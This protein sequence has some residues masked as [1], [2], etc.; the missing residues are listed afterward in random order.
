MAQLQ[1]SNSQDAFADLGSSWYADAT[2]RVRSDGAGRY[3]FL[4]G[5]TALVTEEGINSSIFTV[6]KVVVVDLGADDPMLEPTAANAAQLLGLGTQTA[7]AQGLSLRLGDLLNDPLAV[8]TLGADTVDGTAGDDTLYGGPGSD[9]IAGGDGTDTLQLSGRA[10]LYSVVNDGK[11]TLTITRAA[12]TAVHPI[13]GETVTYA[14]ATDKVTGVEYLE[15]TDQDTGEIVTYAVDGFSQ[16]GDGD[17]IGGYGNDSLTGGAGSDTLDGRAG[18]DAMKGLEG[19]DTYFVDDA[20]DTVTEAA[21]T[22][23]YYGGIDTVISRITYTLGANVENLQLLGRNAIDGTGNNLNNTITGNAGANKLSGGGGDDYFYG[24]GGNDTIDGGA[25]TTV[26]DEY[27]GGDTVY[28]YGSEFDYVIASDG[29]GGL[30]FSRQAYTNEYDQDRAAFTTKVTGIERVVFGDGTIAMVAA[31]ILD[32]S[33]GDDLMAAGYGNDVLTGTSGDDELNGKVGADKMSGSFGNDTYYVD[34]AKDTVTE[35]ADNLTTGD[36]GGDDTVNASVSFVLG[37][38]LENLVLTGAGKIDG[39]GNEKANSLI[40]NAGANKLSGMD[41]NDYI[42]A[43]GGNDVIDGGKNTADGDVVR[44]IGSL[45]D[46]TVTSDGKGTL[47][48]VHPDTFTDADGID[49]PAFTVTVKGAETIEFE[50]GSSYSTIGRSIADGSEAGFGNDTITGTADADEID[51]SVGADKMTGLGGDDI[52]HVDDAKDVV[53]EAANQGTDVVYSTAAAYTLAANVE[54]LYLTGHGRN[55]TGNGVANYIEG[56]ELANSLSGMAGDDTLVSNGGADVLDGG[57]GTDLAI[58]AGLEGDYVATKDSSGALIFTIP[59]ELD[60][61]GGIITPAS[62][63]KVTKVE[64]IQF[65]DGT[66]ITTLNQTIDATHGGDLSATGFGNDIV[67]GTADADDIDGRLGADTMSGGGGDDVYHVD[68]A[69]DVVSEVAGQGTD[70]VYSSVSFTLGANVEH[71]TLTGAA[72]I[73]GTGNGDANSLVGN[74]GANTLKGMGGNDVLAGMGGNDTLDGGDGSDQAVFD[75]SADAF[76]IT[77]G[78]GGAYTLAHRVVNDDGKVSVDYRVNLIGI[79]TATFGDGS[80]IH[81]DA[82][83]LGET[84][85]LTAGGYGSDRLTGGAASETLDGGYGADAMAGNGGDDTYYVDNTGDSVTEIADG[86][87]DTVYSSVTFTLGANVENLVLSGS[88]AI[89]GTGNEGSNT[90]IGNSGINVLN[91]GGG[92]DVLSGGGGNDT[93]IGGSGFDT[94]QF[95]GTLDQY[96]VVMGADGVATITRTILVEDADTGEQ[97]SVQAD[98]VR[99]DAL[100]TELATFE[101]GEIH[102]DDRVLD[103]AQNDD[104]ASGGYGK[105]TIIGSIGDDTIDGGYGVDTMTG[106]DGNDTYYVDNQNDKI[107][108]L[109]DEGGDTVYASVSYTLAD[110]LDDLVLQ[111]SAAI[112]GTGNALANSITGNEGVNVLNGGG[113]ADVMAGGGGNDTF[114]GGDGVDTVMFEGALTEY[115]IDPV[116]D[117]NGYVTVKHIVADE[118]GEPTGTYDQV[119]KIKNDVELL[120]FDQIVHFDD[121]VIDFADTPAL[122]GYGHDTITGTENGDEIDGGWNS[123]SMI[124]GAGDDTYYVDNA[125]DAITET[126]E[127]GSGNDTVH[128]T[129][130]Y[131]LGANVENLTLEDGAGAINGTGNGL[132]NTLTGNGAVNTLDGGDGND[133]LSGGGGND[134]LIGGGGTDTATFDGNLDDYTLT[135]AYDATTAAVTSVKVINQASFETVTVTGVE[136][137]HFGDGF[138]VHFGDRILDADQGDDPQSGGYGKETIY[139]GVGDDFI[140]GGYAA[141]TMIGGDGNDTY[142]VDNTADV[143]SEVAGQGDDI[144]YATATYTLGAEVESLVLTG[145]TAINGTGNATDNTLTGNLG[146]NTLSGLGGNDTLMGGGGNDTLIGG[147]GT[148]VAVFNGELSEYTATLASGKV[149]L[150]RAAYSELNDDGVMVLRPAFTA[151][152]DSVETVR[153]ATELGDIDIGVAPV[154]TT[155]DGEILGSFAADTLKGGAGGDI[156]NGYWGID[157][158]TGGDGDDTYYVDNSKDVITEVADQGYDIVFASDT[159]TLGANVEDLTLEGGKAIN[160]TGNELGNV[161]EGNAAANVLS[162]M[163]GDDTLYGHGGNDTIDGGANTTVVD[164]FEGGDHV[165][166]EGNLEDFWI[167]SDGTTVKVTHAAEQVFDDLTGTW[168]TIPSWT[169]SVTKVE[170]FDFDD[171]TVQMAPM[172]ITADSGID[173]IGGFGNDTIT[174]TDGGD[175]INGRAGGDT[176]TGGQGDDHYTVDD[177][178]D[179]VKESPDSDLTGY[180]GGYDSVDAYVTY[181]LTANVEDLTLLGS[182]KDGTGNASANTITGNAFAN[183]L[184]GMGGDDT[185]IGGGGADTIDGG[186]NSNVLDGGGD[187]A[188]VQGFEEDYTV[189]SDGT[190]VKLTHAAYLEWDD[191]LG[192]D[193]L[194]PAYTVT[195]TKCEYITFEDSGTTVTTIAQK[196]DFNEGGGEAG[197]GNDTLQ[198]SDGDDILDGRAGNDVMNGRYGSDTYYVDSAKDVLTEVASTADMDGGWDVVYSKVTWTLGANFEDLYLDEA[199]G[200]TGGTGNDLDNVITGNSF[201]NKLVGGK[202]NDRLIGNGGDDTIDGGAHSA[203]GGDTAYFAGLASEYFIGADAKGVIQVISNGTWNDDLGTIS[204]PWTAKVTGVEFF[205]FDDVTLDYVKINTTGD[206]EVFGSLS[207]DILRG[208]EGDDILYGFAGADTMIGGRG[209]DTYHVDNAKDV[210]T[211]VANSGDPDAVDQVVSMITYTLGAN[212]ENLSLVGTVALDGTGNALDNCLVGNAGINKLS[213]GDGNDTLSGMGGNDTLTGGNGQDVFRFAAGDGNDVITDFT[214][215]AGNNQDHIDLSEFGFMD[216]ADFRGAGGSI[217]EDGKN[218][219]INVAYEDEE[220]NA[221]VQ[222]I[223]LNNIVKADFMASLNSVMLFN[224]F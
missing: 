23:D 69:K 70:T 50:D 160:G 11:G 214:M 35:V 223:V 222:S 189:T 168:T 7:V 171:Q 79:E 121:Q 88:A 66:E 198:G 90:I 47:T 144:V 30:T 91:G 38:N 192:E 58:L 25:N 10:G 206:G 113:G 68:D 162:G 210:V 95:E 201:A 211:E 13:T 93:F 161:I 27:N 221:H 8:L 216:Y 39:T 173:F 80:T 183:K 29:K 99:F 180:Y 46:Y 122:G 21:D 149:T 219:K 49:R 131:T 129:V 124:G 102:F 24:D 220:G 224:G 178:K 33:K 31:K 98:V 41:G 119:L 77:V 142:Y 202:G 177:A 1:Y 52:Y 141:D 97:V 37:K 138:D 125:N 18:V 64:T 194:R 209:S 128:T 146:V 34:D 191:I 200:A 187:T 60:D 89:N 212:L 51:G 114:I 26:I 135:L 156:L 59:A 45:A 111:G 157:T 167:T 43:G 100:T 36:M 12:Y 165:V 65:G 134:T 123:D 96:S 73:S 207:D 217:V 115:V 140:N 87:E 145:T 101:D 3:A 57:D 176:M 67:K 9:T 188:V 153:F 208:G 81:F 197:Y 203:G 42:V 55:G 133:T 205:E 147:D 143:V 4:S 108:E 112:N 15:F 85:D 72:A 155:G 218:T 94:V 107:V 164:Q 28:F 151:I 185:L 213:G 136:I 175:E 120:Q 166:F 163:A 86:G 169:A 75:D 20:K 150:S 215:A 103:A 44:L 56:N 199:G 158:L 14:A 154:N 92:S 139:G 16:T 117:A 174:G 6:S 159:Y 190:T 19:D 40:G 137:I 179:V 186:D 106:G 22:D 204:A 32:A 54:N 116:Q 110:N 182:A 118:F 78:T 127:E 152:L 130:T 63:I 105:E 84:D 181:T 196:I 193:V 126:G 17:V 82:Q 61:V 2:L 170:F 48:F 76:D 53:V 62:S 172:T 132:A 74:A 5:T 104:L 109:E 184:S 71:L 148:D 83:T 195:I